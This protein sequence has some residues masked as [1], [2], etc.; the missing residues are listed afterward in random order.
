MTMD[1]PAFESL[2]DEALAR[3]MERIEDQLGDSLDV[4]LQDGILTIELESGDQYVINKHRPNRQI[5]VSSPVSGAAH[6]D[7]DAGTGQWVPTRGGAK[8]LPALLSEE[9]SAQAGRPVTLD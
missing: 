2:A 8:T 7:H 3:L 5:W 6:F 9:L 4:D 1:E